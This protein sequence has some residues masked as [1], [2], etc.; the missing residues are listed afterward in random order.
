MFELVPGYNS[1][2]RQAGPITAPPNTCFAI[3]LVCC[4]LRLQLLSH[5][6]QEELLLES[7]EP[8]IGFQRFRGLLENRRL[9]VLKILEITILIRFSALAG[10]VTT[11]VQLRM[12]FIA[13][14]SIRCP[15]TRVARSSTG[16]GRGGGGGG[17]TSLWPERVLRAICTRHAK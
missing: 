6:Q 13:S 4:I 9:G 1:I 2:G 5:P 16:V 12:V 14:L 11:Q 3:Q 17:G 7:V 8:F 10:M 15:S